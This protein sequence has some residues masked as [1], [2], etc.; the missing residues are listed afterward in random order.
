[1]TMTAM[2]TTMTKVGPFSPSLEM[3]CNDNDASINPGMLD[4]GDDGID[5][6][7]D[8]VEQEGLCD[9][10]CFDAGDGY[11]D[12]GGPNAEYN[13]C[14]FGTDCSDCGARLDNDG[15]GFYDD[16]GVEPLEPS[17]GSRL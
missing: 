4:I 17:F 13:I 3:D 6:D 2:G 8:G 1:M 10:T 15:D 11:C 5:Q 12:D 9:D 7:C 14:G 16:Q